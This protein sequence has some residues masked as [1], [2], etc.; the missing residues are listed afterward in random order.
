MDIR[1]RARRAAALL[2]RADVRQNEYSAA[3]RATK[4]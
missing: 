1:Y 3:R 2:G 4:T